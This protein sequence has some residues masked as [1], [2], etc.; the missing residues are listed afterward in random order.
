MHPQKIPITFSGYR[1]GTLDI[2]CVNEMIETY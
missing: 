1:R 2:K